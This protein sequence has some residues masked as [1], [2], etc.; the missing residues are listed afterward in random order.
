MTVI[1][2]RNDPRAAF[3]G[4]ALDT[5]W[6]DLHMLYFCGYAMWQY[7]HWPFVLGRPDIS[8]TEAGTHDEG[9]E[10]WQVLDVEFPEYEVLA[11]HARKQRFYVSEEGKMLRRHDYAPDVLAA[12][13]AA[14]YVYDYVE[15]GGLKFPTVRRVVAIGPVGRDGGLAPMVY[16]PVPTLINLVILE[17]V[18]QGTDG[19]EDTWALARG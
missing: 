7:F 18:L 2:S 13:P 15:V 17:I 11:T 4:H 12:S 10:S 1:E 16:G 8:I 5:Q 3:D 19:R 14:H 6:D 9:E